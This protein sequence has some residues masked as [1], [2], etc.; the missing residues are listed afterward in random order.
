MPPPSYPVCHGFPL[1]AAQ[2]RYH[3]LAFPL[4][5]PPLAFC[6]VL[7]SPF[8]TALIVP[9]S[10]LVGCGLPLPAPTS[11]VGCPPL[12]LLVVACYLLPHIHRRISPHHPI[13]P[14]SSVG[15]R[16]LFF[17]PRSNDISPHTSP[18]PAGRGPPLLSFK[19]VVI[20]TPCVGSG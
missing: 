7:L 17:A 14:R 6:R 8:P 5:L 3:N 15:R 11:L 13:P 18:F 20:S 4:S 2:T 12:L 9:P 10:F 1:S 16:L 19:S